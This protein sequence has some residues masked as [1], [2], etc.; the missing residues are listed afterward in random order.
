[1]SWDEFD[2]AILRSAMP[3]DHVTVERDR[4]RVELAQV[5]A[6][7]AKADALI[8]EKN[9]T[10]REMRR[11]PDLSARP[12]EWVEDVRPVNPTP[13]KGRRLVKQEAFDAVV[14]ERD[15]ALRERDEAWRDRLALLAAVDEARE[16][17]CEAI[18]HLEEVTGEAEALERLLGTDGSTHSYTLEAARAFLLSMGDH[19]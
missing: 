6:E 11:G 18:H 12:E 8:E 9:A 5:K 4:L 10:M 17:Q 3:V 16:N 13:I 1:M 15:T 19:R 14:A 2:D 7:L